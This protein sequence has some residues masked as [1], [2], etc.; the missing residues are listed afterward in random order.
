[1]KKR[2]FSFLLVL[3][4]ALAACTP[5]IYGVPEDRWET[6]SEQERIA[7]METYKARQEALRQQREERARQR[8]MEEKARLAR[9]AEEARLRQIRVDA[10]YRGEGQYGELL[11]VTLSGGEL[12][13]RGVHKPYHPVS[14]RIAA[15]EIK[16]VEVVSMRG[17]KARM[18]VRYDGS[19]LLLDDTPK[20]RYSKAVRL[21]FEDAWERG[22]TYPGLVAKGPLEIRGVDV[23]VQLIGEPPRDHR[24]R[25]RHPAVEQPRAH[26]PRVPAVVVI[27]EPDRRPDPG[28]V[29]IDRRP[30]RHK[31]DVI[32]VQTPPETHAP[33]KIVVHRRPHGS[34]AGSARPTGGAVV[35]QPARHPAAEGDV[36]APHA[37]G[38]AP[39][40]VAAI[41]HPAVDEHGKVKTR[42]AHHNMVPAVPPA[43]ITVAFRKGRFKVKKRSYSLD[44]QTI[45][46]VEGESRDIVMGGRKGKLKV[47]VSYIDGEL[48]IDDVPGN[49]RRSTRLGFTPGWKDGQE[50]A[51]ASSGNG[52]LKDLDVLV[53]SQ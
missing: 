36:G 32:V 17:R 20:S 9:E 23:T 16:D 48:L 41:P 27:E 34:G 24:R 38:K 4:M 40:V 6:M 10:I 52:L 13:F 49:N 7:A 33:G 3:M 35:R 15:G 28:V 2:M 8:A 29:V 43:R 51:I 53:V 44:P 50:Y 39:A 30:Q 37:H 18:A 26:R 21:P 25:H 46:L 19:N 42:R 5:R 22:A 45:D 11:R 31:P 47:R 1:M 12:Q 14:F